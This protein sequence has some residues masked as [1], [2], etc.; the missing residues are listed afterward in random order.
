MKGN[1]IIVKV[2]KGKFIIKNVNYYEMYDIDKAENFED[3]I[4]K[5]KEHMKTFKVKYGLFFPEIR[6]FKG[7]PRDKNNHIW[8]KI[9]SHLDEK[10]KKRN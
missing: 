10:V 7:R 2:D 1:L 8:K 9:C 6:P 4:K 3:A 5:A